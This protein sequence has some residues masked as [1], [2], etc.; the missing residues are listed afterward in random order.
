MAKLLKDTDKT[1]QEKKAKLVK[2]KNAILV[3]NIS[4]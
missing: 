4:V 2:Q 1:L 3:R